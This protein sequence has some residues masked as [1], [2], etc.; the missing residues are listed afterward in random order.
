[1][2]LVVQTGLQVYRKRGSEAFFRKYFEK[3]PIDV[4]SLDDPSMLKAQQCGIYHIAQQGSKIWVV[5]GRS[6]MA[7]WM[8]D[9]KA[10]SCPQYWIHAQN[11]P[12]MAAKFVQSFLEEHSDFTPQIIDNTGFNLLYQAPK[13]IVKLLGQAFTV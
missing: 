4:Q 1:M 13:P 7:N 5:D 6:A 10:V 3:S 2:K 11:C 9:F 8:D 12:V